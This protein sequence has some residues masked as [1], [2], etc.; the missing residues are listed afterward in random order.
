MREV[1][2]TTRLRAVCTTTIARVGDQQTPHYAE[3]ESRGITEASQILGSS[4]VAMA[5]MVMFDYV[6]GW[7]VTEVDVEILRRR[8]A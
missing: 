2:C 7:M 1:I 4:Q 8:I 6:H 5:E 3:L